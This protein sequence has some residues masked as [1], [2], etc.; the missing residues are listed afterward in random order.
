MTPYQALHKTQ[1][2][3]SRLKVFGAKCFFKHTRTN[4]KDLDVPG[5]EGIYLGFTATE[6]NI[7]VQSLRSKRI[8]IAL[9]KSFD[10]AF[11]T[12]T[13]NDLPPLAKALRE[14]GYNNDNTTSN[15]TNVPYEEMNLK[16]KLLSDDAIKPTRG[17]EGSA[18]LDVYSTV[19]EMLEPGKHAII[20]LDIAI[21][22]CQGTYAQIATRSSIASKGVTTLGGVI[23]SDYRGNVK[24][25]LQNNSTIPYEINK[26]QRIAQIIIQRIHQP[27][28]NIVT[29]LSDTL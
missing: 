22:T 8:H 1:P 12:S 19:D 16:V 5:E 25:I 4:Q 20:P 23:D 10:E 6:K 24:V 13:A 26:G 27:P 21:Q 29:Q 17:T 7:Y 14:A 9:H 28:V 11:M 15:D 2:D 18:G 3:V